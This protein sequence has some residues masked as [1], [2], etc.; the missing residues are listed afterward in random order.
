MRINGLKELENSGGGIFLKCA[1]LE[2]VRETKTEAA[3]STASRVTADVQRGA[4][5]FSYIS[6]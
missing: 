2:I 3:G 6:V 5:A 4:K 1:R